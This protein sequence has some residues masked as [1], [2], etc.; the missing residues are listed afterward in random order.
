MLGLV[1]QAQA[2]EAQSDDQC[3]KRHITDGEAPPSRCRCV[4]VC[5][6]TT[7]LAFVVLPQ[8]RARQGRAEQNRTDQNKGELRA[9]GEQ[10]RAEQQSSGYPRLLPYA[11]IPR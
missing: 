4:C 5:A 1:R 6:T 2:D 9:K 10:R 3:A 7:V 11:N 8:D